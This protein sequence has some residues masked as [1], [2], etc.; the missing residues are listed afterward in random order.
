MVQWQGQA[1]VLC[2]GHEGLMGTS[3]RGAD[4][5]CVW[6]VVGGPDVQSH[7][8]SLL[9]PPRRVQGLQI[10]G[11][12]CGEAAAQWITSFLKTQPYRLVHFEPHMSPRNSHQIEHLFRPTDQV[13]GASLA[14][15]LALGTRKHGP[16]E[17]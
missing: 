1:K 5:G 13:R 6:D 9:L 16:G 12:D 8:C 4:L 17:R 3:Q 2:L 7:A 10:Q 14:L 15:A 11:R